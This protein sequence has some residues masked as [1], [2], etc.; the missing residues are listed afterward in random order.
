MTSHLK[1]DILVQALLTVAEEMCEHQRKS[2][3]AQALQVNIIYFF[4]KIDAR[5]L[6]IGLNISTV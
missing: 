4:V 1:V 5:D 6:K 3:A 2:L